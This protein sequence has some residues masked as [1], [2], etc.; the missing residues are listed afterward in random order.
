MIAFALTGIV[1]VVLGIKETENKKKKRGLI[2]F[3]GEFLSFSIFAMSLLMKSTEARDILTSIAVL[4]A[5][6]FHAF[7][8]AFVIGDYRQKRNE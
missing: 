8:I 7:L 3:G 4:S 2:I 5:L 6:V 1:L